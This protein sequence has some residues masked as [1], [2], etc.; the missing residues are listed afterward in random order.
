MTS[1]SHEHIEQPTSGPMQ[2]VQSL[3]SL[4]MFAIN[5]R[6]GCIRAISLLGKKLFEISVD[7]GGIGRLL[8]H[9]QES[10]VR[11]HLVLC[12][13]DVL[14]T[15]SLEI[16]CARER[17]TAKID[18]RK[19]AKTEIGRVGKSH[20][21]ELSWAGDFRFIKSD[22]AL[23]LRSISNERA[24]AVDVRAIYRSFKF[25]FVQANRVCLH[26]VEADGAVPV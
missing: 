24:R 16:K 18:R 10:G 2:P 8:R 11:T 5:K 21:H 17:R 13:A 12:R 4:A 20:I 19:I 25:A 22:P 15:H 23:E 14:V 26:R 3:R 1:V 7:I 9:F 6:A